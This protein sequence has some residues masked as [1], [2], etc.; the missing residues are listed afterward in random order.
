MTPAILIWLAGWIG[1]LAGG[2]PSARCDSPEVLT[3]ATEFIDCARAGTEKYRDRSK[4][5]VDGYRR[6]GGDFPAMGEHWIRIS[7]LFDGRF[8]AASPEVLNY[9]VVDG[10]PQLLGVGYAVPLLGEETPPRGPAGP[11]AWHDHTRSISD[12]TILPHHHAPGNV[13]SGARLAMMH[14]WIWSP[15]PDGT[16]AADNW[17]LPFVR[18]GLQPDPRAPT[19]SA[20]ALSLASG[21]SSYFA[22]SIAA[23][24]GHDSREI[25]AAFVRAEKA[26]RAILGDTSNPAP[27][28]THVTRLAATW[29][30]LWLEIDRS[31]DAAARQRLAHLPI[32]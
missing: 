11:D 28:E 2:Q 23:V 3:S 4:A 30:E 8:D 17:A 10:Q 13:A 29:R 9:V 15:N 20:K 12:E 22:T 26:V 32:R 7:S 18:L 16:F 25:A 14:A 5:I 31:L 21:G 19:A 6:I 27:G 24:T 1:Q